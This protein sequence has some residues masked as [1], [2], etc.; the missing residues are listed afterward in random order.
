MKNI[1]FICTGN[2]CRSPMAEVLFK[3]KTGSNSPWKSSSAGTHALSGTPASLEAQIVVNEIGAN[4]KDHNSK[5]INK[6]LIEEAD[7]ILVMTKGHQKYISKNF[8]NVSHRVY[9]INELGTSKVK[10]ISDP[11]GSA[12]EIYRNTCN[13]IAHAI[14]ELITFL[15]LSEK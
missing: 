8:S 3:F 10:D 2:T 6:K 5:P 11:Y 14:D 4:L 9:L 7:L 13:E 12:I 1:L 15:K